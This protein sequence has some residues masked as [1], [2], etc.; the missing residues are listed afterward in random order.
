MI[1]L[2]IIQSER[3]IYMQE[4][5]D[6]AKAFGCSFYEA[7]AK[8]NVNVNEVF[9]DIVREIRKQTTVHK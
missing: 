9:S 7:S 5:A 4:G 6:L 3:Q 1:Y 8:N 2:L